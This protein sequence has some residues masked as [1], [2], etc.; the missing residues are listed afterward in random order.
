MKL[1]DSSMFQFQ[2]YLVLLTLICVVLG[3]IA[4]VYSRYQSDT[5]GLF[6]LSIPSY[7]PYPYHLFNYFTAFW[8]PKL[9]RYN[10]S[11]RRYCKSISPW[12]D[13]DLIP[14]SAASLTR[15]LSN[16]QLLSGIAIFFLFVKSSSA[17][18]MNPH[19]INLNGPFFQGWLVRTVDTKHECSFIT[20]IGSF[21][22][23]NSKDYSEH[24]LFCA[25]HSKQGSFQIHKFPPIET[26]TINGSPSSN[27][28]F[29]YSAAPYKPADTLWKADGIG[30]FKLTDEECII[31]FK[32]DGYEISSRS[33]NRKSFKPY[34][35]DSKTN[36]GFRN[37]RYDS[38][39]G[40]L[41]LTSALP[42]HYHIH[43]T[44][45][46][47]TSY[48]IK[49]PSILISNNSPSSAFS[50][51]E[52]NHGT[53]FPEGWVWCQAI[54][55]D[56]KASLSFVGGK[57]VISMIKPLT[58][59][60]Y[61]RSQNYGT[62]V[63]RTTDLDKMEYLIDGRQ[64]RVKITTTSLSGAYKLDIDVDAG[65]L[66]KFGEAVYIP[67]REGFTNTPGCRETYTAN[68]NIKLF[69]FDKLKQEYHMLEELNIPQTAL[70]F[71]ALFQKAL[72]REG[73]YK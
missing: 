28:K 34:T 23:P 73:K 37:I 61:F 43:S 35:A 49:S 46:I 57:F 27:H 47:C 32:L 36:E 29:L 54:A 64:G 71:G 1:F 38:P 52:G 5:H 31:D 19:Y 11:R 17:S 39:E 41:A 14:H 68:A 18:P 66:D 15:E 44:G 2:N 30:S 56:N 72:Y 48:R 60:I 25:C 58:F 63:F 22:K 26:V 24:Y 12:S 33:I 42:C 8:F 21:S 50:H 67:T 65:S 45:S 40:W 9:N 70:E 51:I 53:Y 62:H 16:G 55:N 59:T 6:Q 20:I 3:L 4:P 10:K 13:P 69:Q 7:E